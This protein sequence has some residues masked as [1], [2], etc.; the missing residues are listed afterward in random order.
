MYS[1]FTS[2]QIGEIFHVIII[3]IGAIC[4][5]R[6][7]CL[8]SRI[9]DL[10]TQLKDTEFQLE[11]MKALNRASLHHITA[12]ENPSYSQKLPDDS[13]VISINAWKAERSRPQRKAL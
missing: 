2:Q 6:E 12:L 10:K 13:N 5:S 7:L 3:V 9:E 1:E 8:G 4:L 11:K